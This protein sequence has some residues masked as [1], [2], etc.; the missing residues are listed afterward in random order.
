MSFSSEIKDI[1]INAPYKNQC[2]RRALVQGAAV[3]KARL[4]DNGNILLNVEKLEYAEFISALIKQIY[5]NDPT[6]GAPERGGRCKCISFKSK[7]LYSDI[8]AARDGK[9]S[10]FTQKC[11]ACE[12]AFL[13]GVF[14]SSGRLTDPSKAFCLEFSLG[15]EINII[16]EAFLSFGLDFKRAQRRTESLLYTKNSTVIEDFFAMAAVTEATF[17]VINIKFENEQKNIANRQTNLDSGNISRSVS[18]AG[19]QHELISELAARGMMSRLPEELRA[20]A[21]LRLD[22]PEMS[23]SQ[24]AIHSSPPLTRS[25]LVHRMNRIVKLCRELLAVG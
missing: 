19:M 13:R 9:G 10:V 15:N 3:A 20:T 14:L 24:L 21:Q 2:C 22:H 5:G 17:A 8:A 23:L 7:S 1:I 4:G 12:S 11:P 16:Y 18:A 25:G 6:V